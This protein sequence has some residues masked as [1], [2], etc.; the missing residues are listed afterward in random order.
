MDKVIW[1]SYKLGDLFNRSTAL[2]M[3]INQKELNLVDKKDDTHIVALISASR[4]GSGRVGY[5]EE[6]L[7]DNSKVSINKLTFDD[8]WGYTFF[9]QEEF[10]IT[11]GHNAILEIIDEKLKKLLDKNTYCY[12]FLS[13]IINNITIKTGIYGY[14]YKINNKLDREI[15]LLPCLE[16]AAGEDYIWE[17]NGKH[18]TLAI[19]YISYLYLS[20]KVNYNQELIDNYTYQY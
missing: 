20:S 3:G 9:Q 1:K 11:G 16:V 13:L 7:V 15:I 17:E 14:G 8:Q 10:V 4:N 12:S 6:G 2:A 18:Y 19:N 5:I